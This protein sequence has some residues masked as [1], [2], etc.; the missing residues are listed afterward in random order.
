MQ[1]V[2]LSLSCLPVHKMPAPCLPHK[3][4]RTA[5]LP[6]RRSVFCLP[7]NDDDQYNTNLRGSTKRCPGVTPKSTL[8]GLPFENARV[9]LFVSINQSIYLSPFALWKIRHPLLTPPPPDMPY[10]LRFDLH[11]MTCCCLRIRL[12]SVFFR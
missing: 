4:I 10:N 7:I 5:V 2:S 11:L 9:A 8:H 3:N 12:V 1:F 6:L